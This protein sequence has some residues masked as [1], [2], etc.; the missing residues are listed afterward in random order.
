VLSWRG[1]RLPPEERILELAY[2][3]RFDPIAKPSYALMVSIG[4]ARESELPHDRVVRGVAWKQRIGEWAGCGCSRW[5][6]LDRDLE[7]WLGW[8]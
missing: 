8:K 3:T 4:R 6:D 2:K 1:K 5:K 7:A